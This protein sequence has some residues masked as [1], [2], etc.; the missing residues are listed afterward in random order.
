MEETRD[1]GTTMADDRPP[2]SMHFIPFSISWK[3]CITWTTSFL[4]FLPVLTNQPNNLRG[5][6]L[7]TAL[8]RNNDVGAVLFQLGSA[9]LIVAVF[10]L[11][12]DALFDIHDS[13]KHQSKSKS[14]QEAIHET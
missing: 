14:T 3:L 2:L 6:S 4:C 5:T 11:F 9:G 12:I 7:S 1:I 10:P 8:F 13:F